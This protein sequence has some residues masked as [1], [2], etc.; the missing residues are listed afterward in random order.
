MRSRSAATF[1]P[2]HTCVPPWITAAVPAAVPRRVAAFQRVVAR[3]AEHEAVEKR[4]SS[5]DLAAYLDA[6]VRARI[7]PDSVT[8]SSPLSERYG[9]DFDAARHDIARCHQN[10]LLVAQLSAQPAEPA[11][12][13]RLDAVRTRLD[14]DLE[15][16]VVRVEEWACA[17]SPELADSARVEIGRDTARQAASQHPSRSLR[18]APDGEIE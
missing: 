12:L 16:V 14:A 7:V 10:L 11:R 15:R 5:P 4:I 8:T 9:D 6:G 2:R 13:V 1:S 3:A 17:T 18:P